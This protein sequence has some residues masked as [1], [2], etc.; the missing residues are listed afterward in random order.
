M[1]YEFMTITMAKKIIPYQAPEA[2]HFSQFIHIS[3]RKGSSEM[4]G[5]KWTIIFWLRHTSGELCVMKVLNYDLIFT[6]LRM[7]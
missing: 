3:I 6:L 2:Q 5:P 4:T 1:R 7:K